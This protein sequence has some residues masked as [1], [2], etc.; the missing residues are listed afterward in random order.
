MSSGGR[1][2]FGLP[3][4]LLSRIRARLVRVAKASVV[5]LGLLAA[6]WVVF[7]LLGH[8][9]ESQQAVMLSHFGAGI[10]ATIAIY[11][12]LTR[13]GLDD[14][15]AVRVG[16]LLMFVNTMVASSAA[17]WFEW[18]KNQI[19]QPFGVS[20][21]L[22]LA[23]PLV[24]PVPPRIAMPIA[25]SCA[26]TPAI[27]LTVHHFLGLVPATPEAYVLVTHIHVL[28]VVGA[29]AASRVVYRF[30]VEIE[31]A[32]QLGAY[33]LE[34]KLG[35]G[36]MGEVWRASH[37]MLA[38]PA[39]VKLIRSD[40]HGD[41]ADESRGAIAAA[42]ERE[43]QGT[44]AL[45]S[46]NT[47]RLYD[48]G[49]SDDG[50]FYYVMELLDGIDLETF[51]KSTVRCPLRAPR[52][53]SAR[54]ATRCPMRTIAVWSIGTSSRRTFCF[55]ARGP[56]TT[57]SR[58]SILA[59]SRCEPSWRRTSRRMTPDSRAP[60]VRRRSCHRRRPRRSRSITARIS[61]RWGAWRF[62]C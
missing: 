35:Q 4:P 25:I 29:Y 16:L 59:W 15:W 48:F 37:R 34:S 12:A 57:G 41:R 3:G 38:R 49:Q 39:A 7:P 47:V 45:T 28:A 27:A 60:S 30:S 9:T 36:G 20:P 31:R 56:S 21:M 17:L 13:P 19:Y 54:S 6:F 32:K 22:I 26:A 5:F 40:L 58:S 61:T 46:P 2:A 55:A 50:T 62:G 11:I 53:P 52:S 8:A 24:I 18:D 10:I 43:A 1:T 42:F 14:A 33:T 44:A 23:F 51:V